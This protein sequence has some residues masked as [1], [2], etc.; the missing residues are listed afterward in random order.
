M[1]GRAS[2]RRD[3]GGQRSRLHL[4]LSWIVRCQQSATAPP[5][6]MYDHNQTAWAIWAGLA[7][8]KL[9]TSPLPPCCPPCC[10]LFC[11]LTQS[12]DLLFPSSSYAS[13]CL[14]FWVG[15]V[16]YYLYAWTL[17][18]LFIFKNVWMRVSEFRKRRRDCFCMHNSLVCLTVFIFFKK[19]LAWSCL[20]TL[21]IFR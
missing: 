6:L 10:P 1:R 8:H 13:F 15:V 11:P 12:T 7:N 9:L 19:T 14:C 3:G 18:F 4:I 20:C 5:S 21:F 17:D 16:F 2:S